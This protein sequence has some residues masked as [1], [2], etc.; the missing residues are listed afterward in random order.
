MRKNKKSWDNQNNKNYLFKDNITYRL[1]KKDGLYQIEMK[2]PKQ[3]VLLKDA[4]KFVLKSSKTRKLQRV[5]FKFEDFAEELG[6]KAL[7]LEA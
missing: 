5:L 1:Y 4:V 7:K 2:K 6:N 3:L